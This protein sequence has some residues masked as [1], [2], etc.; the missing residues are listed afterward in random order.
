VAGQETCRL[1]GTTSNPCWYAEQLAALPAPFRIVAGPEVSH[2][3]RVLGERL[4]AAAGDA[5][6]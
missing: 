3:A 6:A 4:L 5:T 1:T 2:A